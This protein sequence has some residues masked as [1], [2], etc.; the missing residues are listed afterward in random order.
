MN[1][2]TS[3]YLLITFAETR[4]SY[5][6]FIQTFCKAGKE[7]TR[8]VNNVFAARRGNAQIAIMPHASAN[9]IS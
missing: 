1:E 7:K 8:M 6:Q 9:I 3:Y 4:G 2:Y 5:N